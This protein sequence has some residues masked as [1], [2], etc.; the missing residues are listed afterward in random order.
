MSAIQISEYPI[1]IFQ[2]SIGTLCI[3]QLIHMKYMYIHVCMHTMIIENITYMITILWAK[4]QGSMHKNEAAVQ[5][6]PQIICKYI[7]V[8][9]L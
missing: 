8:Y 9:H 3:K 6:M 5:K 1:F 7:Y 2:T 4:R